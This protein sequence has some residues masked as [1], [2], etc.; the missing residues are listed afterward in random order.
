MP[1]AFPIEFDFLGGLTAQQRLVFQAAAARI[2]RF[3]VAPLPKVAIGSRVTSGVIIQASGASIDGGGGILGQAGPT[4]L[5]PPISA[6]GKAAYLPS[7]GMMQFDIA[8][9]AAMTSDGTLLDV[10]THEMCHV[11][12]FTQSVWD[13]KRLLQGAATINPTF[14]GA[15]A[16]VQYGALLE[17]ATGALSA[18]VPVPI[19]GT[20]GPGTRNS[21]LRETTF[22]SELMTG[23]VSPPGIK[24]PLSRVTVAAFGDLGY[25]V[26]ISKAEP[27]SLPSHIEM[28]RAQ[29]MPERRHCIATHPVV[30]QPTA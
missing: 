12:G 14:V 24:N 26:D 29:P 11:L 21:H 23:Y 15:F 8:D 30:E 25:T 2:Q 7:M 5:R 4:Y 22:R 1:P 6:M 18:S 3:I 10:I 16:E 19:E 27:F 28:L 13:R 17:G 9:L 20:G